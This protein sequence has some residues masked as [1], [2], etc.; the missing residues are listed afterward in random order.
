MT[1]A[2]YQ[3]YETPN[4]GAVAV[5]QI[6]KQKALDLKQQE[7]DEARKYKQATLD[8]KAK[9]D[10]DKVAAA[11]AKQEG[12]NTKEVG[13][14]QVELAKSTGKIPVTGFPKFNGAIQQYANDKTQRYKSFLPLMSNGTMT[15]GDLNTY[16]AQDI[17]SVEDLSSTVTMLNETAKVATGPDASPS[18]SFAFG[19]IVGLVNPTD[20]NTIS[21][22]DNY[23]NGILKTV[24]HS[25]RKNEDGEEEHVSTTPLAA[26]KNAVNLDNYKAHDPDKMISEL[27][28]E[29]KVI[30][31]YNL[32][33]AGAGTKVIDQSNQDN[34]KKAIDMNI[35]QVQSNPYVAADF[36]KK[37][38]GS[39]PTKGVAFI[40]AD[41]TTEEKKK[42]ADQAGL[43]VKDMDFVEFKYDEKENV[44]MPK[45]TKIQ[46]ERLANAIRDKWNVMAEKSTMPINPSTTNVNIK[47]TVEKK[48]DEQTNQKYVKLYEG[49]RGALNQVRSEIAAANGMASSAKPKWDGKDR[50]WLEWDADRKGL[51][52]WTNTSKDK[53]NENWQWDHI[54]LEGDDAWPDPTAHIADRIKQATE[55]ANARA[56]G[57]AIP[58]TTEQ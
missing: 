48:V 11:K 44:L 6:D 42:I 36:Y 21:I 22:S 20:N 16:K 35:K 57:G 54:M 37:L 14:A 5:E 53:L 4:L 25:Y 39:D 23:D 26:V 34:Y 7:L 56:A 30:P 51:I 40:K 45:L 18:A 55:S 32:N 31:Q 24:V 46:N 38:Y 15:I 19:E 58:K 33:K 10:A 8:A 47:Q 1:Y 50:D 17:G 9:E 52:L 27:Q 13:S 12:E 28:K 49:N 43:D 41:A 29:I 3:R 2:G